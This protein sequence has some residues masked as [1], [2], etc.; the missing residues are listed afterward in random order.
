MCEG[1]VNSIYK[2]T[3]LKSSALHWSPSA[4][5]SQASPEGEAFHANPPPV[6]RLPAK[7]P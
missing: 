3:W 5:D 6:T 4:G 7:L 1:E 2:L